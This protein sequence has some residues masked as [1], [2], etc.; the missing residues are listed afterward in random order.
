MS[1]ASSISAPAPVRR[2]R[3]GLRLLIID[4]DAAILQL[5][6]L[7]FARSGWAVDCATE[8]EEAQA[9]L[10]NGRYD[11]LIAD[12]RLTE[13]SPSEGLDVIAFARAAHP[14]ARVIA[15][16]GGNAPDLEHAAHELGVSAVVRKPVSPLAIEQLLHG[17]LAEVLP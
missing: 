2:D 12:L 10:V 15:Y 17:F 7:H 6:R 13:I 3:A 1:D 11:A 5:L 16:S 4:D 14:V 8:R 9:L